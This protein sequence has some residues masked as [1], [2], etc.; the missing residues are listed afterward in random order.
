V[1]TDAELL[2]R[3]LSNF[4][5]NALKYCQRGGI[6]VSARPHGPG[7][8]LAV[9]DT[10]RGIDDQ[11]L[12]RLFEE[13]Y[14]VDNAHRDIAN[15]LGIGLAI[16]KRLGALLDGQLGLR[17]VPG[18]GSVFWIDLPELPRNVPEPGLPPDALLRALPPVTQTGHARPNVLLL[19]DEASVCEAMRIWLQPHCAA[20]HVAQTL[21]EARQ[22]MAREGHAIDAMV[23]DFR[24]AGPENGIEAT[25]ML[26][27]AARREV[28][29]ILVTGDT[30]P[31]R[32][33]AA[34][35]SGLVV[36]FKPVQ[37]EQLVKALHAL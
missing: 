9:W 7:V 35:E 1:F 14:Q 6:L 22:L 12:P 26:R 21:E 27:G 28:P 37:P 34:Y 31:A 23:V 4:T 18:R 2:F 25:R 20:I 30:D 29:A 16:V 24:L 8:R 36:M 10:G 5:D 15:G 33:R 32:V 19:D 17:S 11:H 3:I 13:F